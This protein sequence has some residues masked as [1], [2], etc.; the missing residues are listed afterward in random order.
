[1][2]YLLVALVCT[3]SA[4]AAGF[5]SEELRQINEQANEN[6]PRQLTESLRFNG[7]LATSF[8]FQQNY[9]LLGVYSWNLDREAAAR[10]RFLGEMEVCRN[11]LFYKA[12]QDR[13]I[14]V[15]R[16]YRDQE[17]SLLYSVE[18]PPKACSLLLRRP[19]LEPPA[20]RPSEITPSEGRERL[21]R[22][23]AERAIREGRAAPKSTYRGETISLDFTNVALGAVF[24]VLSDF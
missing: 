3:P 8:R 9:T 15:A 21:R 11:D 23:G 12:T 14:T 2:A 19:D 10:A 17:G 13:G 1:M 6:T 4:G 22:E 7:A 20:A 5:T 24:G 18:V 16:F